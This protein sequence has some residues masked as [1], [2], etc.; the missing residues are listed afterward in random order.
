[1]DPITKKFLLL[2]TLV[3]KPWFHWRK[4]SYFLKMIW[5]RQS[6]QNKIFPRLDKRYYWNSRK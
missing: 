2:N 4:N 5:Q 3:S 6:Y 1:M